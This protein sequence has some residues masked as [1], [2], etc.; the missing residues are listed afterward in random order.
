[1]REL[2]R[3]AVTWAIA[4]A[5]VVA[6]CWL[7]LGRALVHDEGLATYFF[8]RYVGEDFL[9]AFFC[10]KFKPIVAA[11]YAPWA[12]LGL[13][14]FLVAHVLVGGAGV[15]LAGRA[16]RALGI[17]AS[18]LA[19]AVVAFS[20]VYLVGGPLGLSNVDGV[21]ALCLVL[22][23]YA[24]S[25]DS[26][27]WA[28]M[29]GV[30]PWIRY[31]LAVFVAVWLAWHVI[32]RRRWSALAWAAAFPLAYLA[33]GALYHRDILWAIHFP[34]SAPP[35]GSN[36][37][38]SSV[39]AEGSLGQIVARIDLVTPLAAVALL[40][41]WRSMRGAERAA[42]VYGAVYLLALNVLPSFQIVNFDYSARY[43]LEVLP[44]VAL[45][46]ARVAGSWGER[47]AWHWAD[48]LTLGVVLLLALRVRATSDSN[49]ELALAVIFA[50]AVVLGR[51]VSPLA[52]T[53]TLCT[54]ALASP[55]VMWKRVRDQGY[56][57]SPVLASTAGWLRSHPESVSGRR[58][59]TDSSC[60]ASYLE[61]TG[62]TDVDVRYLEGPDQ[63]YE[64][65]ALTDARNG[66]RDA[67][68]RL[69]ARTFYGRPELLGDAR[70]GD[71]PDGSLF[72][73]SEDA[74]LPS[75]LSAD[76]RRHLRALSVERGLHVSVLDL[77][78]PPSAA[79]GSEDAAA[80]QGAGADV[81]AL[82]GGLRPG[83]A[84][85]TW[86]VEYL[87]APRDR[88]LRI[89]VRQGMFSLPLFVAR[90]DAAPPW[91]PR[92]TS[93]YCIF[94]GLPAPPVEPVP[95]EEVDDALG[96]LAERI[97]QTEDEVPVPA[98]L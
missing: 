5:Y 11:F 10:Q 67:V 78:A 26:R 42:A 34:P 7:L 31:E 57:P 17:G 71:L 60:L 47:R 66:Q 16:A 70:A 94:Y 61:A 45:L 41:P 2:D 33:A 83:D 12:L 28:L 85:G 3:P 54:V 98:G 75:R 9:P 25:P 29:L 40:A 56:G 64:I 65:A 32:A 44:V 53:L 95:T 77:T 96:A 37:L 87:A 89:D 14:T 35:Q 38:W 86:T 13:R 92:T 21:V 36:R 27:A 68:L 93:R 22:V 51:T 63:A 23:L 88:V 74:R 62:M 18:G 80:E 1:M 8:A 15:V 39:H 4:G 19:A 6:G 55:A 91:P 90:L 84:L 58:V 82:L 73:L 20:P 97:L 24:R 59:Y 43:S 46:V 50:V 72:V 69:V 52:A 81:S 76:V 48:A 79:Y 49:I 30:L